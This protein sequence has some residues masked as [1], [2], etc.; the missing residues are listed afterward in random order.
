[1]KIIG[2]NKLAQA[3]KVSRTTIENWC[4]DGCPSEF[5]G[6]EHEFTL[7]KVIVW[8]E[9]KF[10]SNSSDTE[11]LTKARAVIAHYRGLITELEYRQKAG[12][13]IPA[14]DV[15]DAAFQTARMVRDQLL[16]I[17]A[18]IS[19]ILGAISD[20]REINRILT[21]EI[22]QCLESLCSELNQSEGVNGEKN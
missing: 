16:N 18:R 3:F 13:L 19:P 2:K 14:K 11:S 17:P 4:R 6:K 5:N 15:K 22:T 8:H 9:K 21:K 20:H 12:E 7:S 1:M 10:L